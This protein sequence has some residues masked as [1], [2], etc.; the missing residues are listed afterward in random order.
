MQG[1]SDRQERMRN[2]QSR[3]EAAQ[4]SEYKRWFTTTKGSSADLC[5][6]CDLIADREEGRP[7]AA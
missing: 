3:I 2:K 5:A 1:Y 4:C 7:G 6:R